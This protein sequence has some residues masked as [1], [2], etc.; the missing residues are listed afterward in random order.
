MKTLSKVAGA[1]AGH[2]TSLDLVGTWEYTG[3]SVAFESDNLLKKAG[4]T[5]AANRIESSID[6]QLEK[7]G[8]QPGITSFTF[9]DDGTFTNTLG[10]RTLSGTCI[11]DTDTGYLTLK[12]MNHLPLKGRLTGSGDSISLLF[13]TSS[14]LSL[15][16]L[17]GSNSGS[18]VISGLSSVT[19]SYDGML[20]GIALSRK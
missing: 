11:Y 7:A 2:F 6:Y 9:N 13:E 19:G 5:V 20:T 17:L 14:F 3:S 1:I 12:Y 4:G 10:G 15:I 18:T 16:T 8:F